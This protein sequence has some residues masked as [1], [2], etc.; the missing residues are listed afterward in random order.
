ML[1]AI[2]TVLLTLAG[3]F[4]LCAWQD[5]RAARRQ[6]RLARRLRGLREGE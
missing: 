4:A 1:T 2:I 3:G 6:E 5:R